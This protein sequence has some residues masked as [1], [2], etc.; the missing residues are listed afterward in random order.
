MA[1]VQASVY[2]LVDD[3]K[4]LR[5]LAARTERDRRSIGSFALH[6]LEH[7]LNQD[8]TF[9]DEL[10]D[11]VNIPGRTK[12]I[13]FAIPPEMQTHLDS[14]RERIENLNFQTFHRPVLLRAAFTLWLAEHS[15]ETLIE[16]LGAPYLLSTA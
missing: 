8:P 15:D 5:N 16:I 11:Y 2:L 10:A 12:H 9:V 7:R 3:E 4:R 13:S 6:Y 1:R 14:L